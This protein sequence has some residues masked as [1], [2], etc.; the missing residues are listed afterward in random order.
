MRVADNA[1]ILKI[2]VVW[3]LSETMSKILMATIHSLAMLFLVALAMVLQISEKKQI[4]SW[5]FKT[6]G[7]T[8]VFF[9]DQIK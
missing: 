9:L 2:I 1:A 7:N 5:V 4:F 3:V 6:I 8:I